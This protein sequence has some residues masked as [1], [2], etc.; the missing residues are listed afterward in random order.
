MTSVAVK[1]T[2]QFAAAVDI[3]PAL[4]CSFAVRTSDGPE[5]GLVLRV[6]GAADR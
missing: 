6:P 3:S 4:M 1:L 5:C 2:A